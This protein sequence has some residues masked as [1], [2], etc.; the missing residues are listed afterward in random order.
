[1]KI[2][3]PDNM[4]LESVTQEDHEFMIDLHNDP[5]V[6]FNLTDPTPVSIESH[7]KW[8]NTVQNDPKSDR[9]IFYVDD[10]KVGVSK[11]YAID[12]TNRNCVLGADIHSKF[13][14]KGYAKYMWTL[15][16]RHCFEV[17]HLHRVGL[18]TAEHNIIGQRVYKKLGFKEEGRTVD[19]TLR[20]G[21]FYDGI[22]MYMTEEMWR[23]A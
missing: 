2:D 1:M 21:V 6:L 23:D 4:R 15:M 3:V 14:G 17:L 20:D 5:T 16:L 9:K 8:W 19:H 12:L 18:S 7:L 11:F 10:V 13:R 22:S